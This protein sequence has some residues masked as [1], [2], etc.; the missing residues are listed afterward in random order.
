MSTNWTLAATTFLEADI[1]ARRSRRVSNTL[2][3]PTFGSLVA[4]A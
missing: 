3:M 2:A 1:S 4:K